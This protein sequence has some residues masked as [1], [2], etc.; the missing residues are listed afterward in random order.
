MYKSSGGRKSQPLKGQPK[1]VKVTHALQIPPYVKY[2][3]NQ[4]YV[5]I[6]NRNGFIPYKCPDIKKS[7]KDI[8]V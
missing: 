1:S 6:S 5:T 7:D 4:D 3:L 8:F 2:G